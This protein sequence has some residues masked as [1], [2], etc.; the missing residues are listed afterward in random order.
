MTLQPISGTVYLNTSREFIMIDAN[1]LLVLL[2]DYTDTIKK[3]GEWVSYALTIVTIVLA[4]VTADFHDFIGIPAN[5]WQA[6]FIVTLLPCA[7]MLV[8][9]I[10]NTVRY[11]K[12][13]P[14]KF[15]REIV[16][17]SEKQD[18]TD[19]EGLLRKF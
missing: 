6:V 7:W 14:R 9:K 5:T 1:S 2:Y 15:V 4:L 11:R 18:D 17:N 16:N 8:L 10:I 3:K 13:T 12:T 19:L